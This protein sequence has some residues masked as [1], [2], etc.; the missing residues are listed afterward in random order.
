MKLETHMLENFCTK[1]ILNFEFGLYY[2]PL[3]HR[4]FSLFGL[5][6]RSNVGGGGL[7]ICIQLI[8]VSVQLQVCGHTRPIRK[9]V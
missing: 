8:V 6:G 1:L 7:T 5:M 9:Q 2:C 4:I 3:S